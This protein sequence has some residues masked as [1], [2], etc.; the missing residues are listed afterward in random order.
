MQSFT[1][2]EIMERNAQLTMTFMPNTIEHLGARLYSTMP[3]IIAELV[4][5]SLDADAN[6]ININLYD[7]TEKTISV[8]DDGIGMSF[9]DINNKFLRIG[10]N[11]REDKQEEQHNKTASG[12]LII[13]KKGLGKLSFFGLANQIEITTI[14][15]GTQNSF[16]L[17]WDEIMKPNQS[18]VSNYH[19]TIL[20]YNKKVP[21]TPN[22]TKVTLR[23]IKRSSN[24]NSE[25]LADSLSRYFI[26]DSKINIK[27]QRNNDSPILLDNLRRYSRIDT[28][29]QW[30]IPEAVP[31]YLLETFKESSKIKGSIISTAKP[32]PPNSG[33]RGITLFSRK[34]LVSLPE[35]FSQ[36][37][38]SHFYSYISGWL[39]VDFIDE[40][41]EDVIDTNR[42][43]LNWEN[44][45]MKQLYSFLH[46]LV[47]YIQ[48]EWR[49][50]RKEK[51]N[52]ELKKSTGIDFQEWQSKVPE[53]IRKDL[54]PI[55]TSFTKASE[56]PE[57]EKETLQNAHHLKNLIPPYP[58]FHWRELH[59]ELKKCVYP[60]YKE[61][62]YY[63]A[64]FE[65]CK[66]Y[67]SKIRALT[68][69]PLPEHDLLQNVF[70]QKI[71]GLKLP[72]SFLNLMEL[73]S[74]VKRYQTWRKETVC[75]L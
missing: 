23:G 38:S 47:G 40:L 62:N 3:P 31:D 55:L 61:S 43:A 12:R 37:T 63:T 4:A 52:F 57:K 54:D 19:P 68:R 36:S 60:Y 46:S 53:Q 67:I 39:E 66:L 32:I 15:N 17:D 29:F 2:R 7:K 25:E 73:H 16:L 72:L 45:Y 13:G 42:Q 74:I 21:G 26:I 70:S 6:N 28:E 35:F 14:S 41:E 64:V 58:Y 48:G 50:K 27:I 9:D 33:I 18:T 34:K 65:G 59:P 56:T 22:G 5:N 75:L 49:K 11:R 71:L 10:R 69:L 24:F 1:G 20:E 30:S 44:E 51:Q 8:S